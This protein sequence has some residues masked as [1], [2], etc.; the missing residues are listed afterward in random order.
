MNA[1][2]IL[3]LQAYLLKKNGR[4]QT[5]LKLVTLQKLSIRFGGARYRVGHCKK[6]NQGMFMERI[7]RADEIKPDFEG[8]KNKWEEMLRKY[9]LD[10]KTL[11]PK[12]TLEIP[13]PHCGSKTIDQSFDLNGFRHNTCSECEIMY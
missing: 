5:W 11:N 3:K 4:A 2:F 1:Q 6:Y 13:C 8:L 7:L 12:Y 10:A 9:Y